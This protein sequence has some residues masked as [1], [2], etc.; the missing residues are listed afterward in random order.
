MTTFWRH[1][2][3]LIFQH[4]IS[5]TNSFIY[6]YDEDRQ[7]KNLMRIT[8]A[9]LTTDVNFAYWTLLQFLFFPNAYLK[10]GVCKFVVSFA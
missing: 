4:E 1:W 3:Q 7:T 8:L 6:A 2:W 9:L 5:F 10:D